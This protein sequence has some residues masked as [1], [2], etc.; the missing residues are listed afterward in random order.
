MPLLFEIV[1][2]VIT[3]IRFTYTYTCSIATFITMLT[4]Q[5]ITKTGD[6]VAQNRA[7]CSKPD[8]GA[9]LQLSGQPEL[10]ISYLSESHDLAMSVQIT[11][12]L[13]C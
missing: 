12:G 6:A 5:E 2:N 13:L 4:S 8:T 9:L 11:L 3:D 7:I 10:D 1:P